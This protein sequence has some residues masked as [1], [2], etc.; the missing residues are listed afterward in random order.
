MRDRNGV[1]M[2]N[3]FNSIDEHIISL[4]MKNK[5]EASFYVMHNVD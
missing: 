5:V 4:I 2:F 3:K 1:D